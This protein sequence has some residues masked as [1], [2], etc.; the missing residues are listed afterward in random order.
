MNDNEVD[1]GGGVGSLAGLMGD[2]GDAALDED[3][4]EAGFQHAENMIEDFMETRSET[5]S[6][7]SVQE[8]E[9]ADFLASSADVSHRPD[10]AVAGPP[11]TREP[12]THPDPDEEDAAKGLR[13]APQATTVVQVAGHEIRYNHESSAFIA[14][15]RC[16]DHSTETADCKKQRTANPAASGRRSNRGQGRPLG[17]LVAW[18]QICDCHATGDAHKNAVDSITREQRVQGRKLL[19]RQRGAVELASHERPKVG[20]EDSEPED[21][22]GC[23]S[24]LVF[25]RRK[26]PVWTLS[27]KIEG[28]AA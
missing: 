28:C 24:S 4:Y 16:K 10:A 23:L 2:L 18:L 25:S 1:D 13:R 21:I 3:D 9:V 8:A 6:E 20:D 7:I 14:I 26:H 22:K 27:G 5:E 15:C 12:D 19:M 17:L 11:E